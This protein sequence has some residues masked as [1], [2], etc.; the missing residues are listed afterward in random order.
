MRVLRDTSNS[1]TKKQSQSFF[2]FKRADIDHLRQHF[3][4]ELE[5]KYIELER[6]RLHNS[7]SGGESF[8]VDPFLAPTVIN[9][10]IND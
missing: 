4:P 6:A 7:N 10:N 3:R 1:I 5:E 2:Q 9:T 8:D